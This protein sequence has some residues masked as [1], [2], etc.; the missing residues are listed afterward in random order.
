MKIL[1]RYQTEVIIFLLLM[2]ELIMRVPTME[3]LDTW[4]TTYYTI[5]YRFGFSSRLL[6][7]SLVRTLFPQ[8]YA[9]QL[10]VILLLIAVFVAALTAVVMGLFVRRAN[11]ELKYMAMFLAALWLASPASPSYLFLQNTFG[12]MDTFLYIYT[13]LILLI[14]GIIKSEKKWFA[15]TALVV[16]AVLTHQV[17]VFIFFPFPAAVF[18]YEFFHNDKKV[19]LKYGILLFGVCFALALY[20]QL[21]SK[22]NVASASEM[23]ASLLP[24]TSPQ[25]LNE[26]V[27]QFEYFAHFE[28]HW[29]YFGQYMIGG[30]IKTGTAACVLLAPLWIF[31]IHV[32]RGYYKNA[33]GESKIAGWLMLACHVAYIP[34]FIITVDWGRWM[35]A[36]VIFEFFWMFYLIMAGDA[37][38]SKYMK[39]KWLQIKMNPVPYMFFLVYLAAQGKFDAINTTASANRLVTYLETWL[40]YLK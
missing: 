33:V 10:Y 32:W 5:S 13:I 12:R 14:C 26:T 9:S 30:C 11:S 24:D 25:L 6:I 20:L 17:Y 23:Y 40:G 35:A 22:V 4:C 29:I 15:V 36:L 27:L 21:F 19:Y 38:I 7:G 37:A 2:V 8:L 3:E 34:I 39:E 31:F 28:D 18:M 16:L 1:K